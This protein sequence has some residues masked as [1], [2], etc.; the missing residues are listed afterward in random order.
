MAS[1]FEL[2]NLRNKANGN[3]TN[4]K[5]AHT[6]QLYKDVSST[7][8]VWDSLN[9]K[10]SSVKNYFSN[11]QTAEKLISFNFKKFSD[12]PEL[13]QQYIQYC[14]FG[15]IVNE[16][17]DDITASFFNKFDNDFANFLQHIVCRKHG[18]LD[19]SRLF[20]GDRIFADRVVKEFFPSV[21]GADETGLATYKK[22]INAVLNFEYLEEGQRKKI[23]VDTYLAKKDG[24]LKRKLLEV[25]FTK[26]KPKEEGRFFRGCLPS[27]HEDA[28]EHYSDVVDVVQRHREIVYNPNIEE[29]IQAYNPAALDENLFEPLAEYILN[30]PLASRLQHMLDVSR[31]QTIILNFVGM[32]ADIRTQIQTEIDALNAPTDAQIEAILKKYI[33]LD[34]LDSESQ[35]SLKSYFLKKVTLREVDAIEREI[36]VYFDGLL[37]KCQQNPEICTKI[38]KQKEDLLNTFIITKSLD[39][40]TQKVQEVDKELRKSLNGIIKICTELFFAGKSREK[41]ETHLKGVMLDKYKTLKPSAFLSDATHGEVT[42][43]TEHIINYIIRKICENIIFE[44]SFISLKPVFIKKSHHFFNPMYVLL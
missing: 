29:Q 37:E 1:T 3:K 7:T 42:A 2:Q 34:N 6:R 39:S 21:Y 30:T 4:G 19:S 38:K 40:I 13:R 24:A 15:I 41:L 23:G 18:F 36:N 28:V 11:T 22:D 44:E 31:N 16:N 35:I 20:Y 25:N 27:K 17:G 43:E 33:N 26:A 10:W 5:T 12:F 32:S 8:I 14:L 9:E